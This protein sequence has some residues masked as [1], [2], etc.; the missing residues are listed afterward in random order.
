MDSTYTGSC[1]KVACDAIFSLQLNPNLG[2]EDQTEGF[3]R[4]FRS[5]P[6]AAIKAVAISPEPQARSS[7]VLTDRSGY[8]SLFM[9]ASGGG[10]NDANT[11][12]NSWGHFSIRLQGR[13][14]RESHG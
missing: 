4:P 9:Q 7:I 14:E 2:A 12:D 8:L 3:R 1:Q 5:L 11:G 13:S 10:H 6:A